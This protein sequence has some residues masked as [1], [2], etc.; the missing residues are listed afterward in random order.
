MVEVGLEKRQVNPV[1]QSPPHMG[2]LVPGWMPH[3]LIVVV[4]VGG[5]VVV[6]VGFFTT[7]TQSIFG[8]PTVTSSSWNWSRKV[9]AIGG[10]TGGKRPVSLL[11]SK[12]PAVVGVHCFT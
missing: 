11:Q 6:V 7:G 4:V 12:L 8:G 9:T 5:D 1:P 2:G 10:G 3:C